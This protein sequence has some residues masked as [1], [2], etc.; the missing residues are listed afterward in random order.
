M[1]KI[2]FY[3]SIAVFAFVISLSGVYAFNFLTQF[4]EIEFPG[5]SDETVILAYCPLGFEQVDIE[6]KYTVQGKDFNNGVFLVTN[7]TDNP[8]YYVGYEKNHHADNWIK[9]NGKTTTS[10]ICHME[11]SEHELKPF[12]SATFEIPV[13]KNEK[14]FEAGF[15]FYGGGDKPE[16]TWVEIGRQKVFVEKIAHSKLTV[17]D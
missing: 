13:P 14:P 1:K 9:Q 16:T 11:M 17:L 5:I 7:L 8:V 15:D 3:L 2:L 4:P 6:Y 12:E 10:L